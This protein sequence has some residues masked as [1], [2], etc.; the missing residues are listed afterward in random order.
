MQEDS[1]KEVGKKS[2]WVF[3]Y[4]L[5]TK[6]TKKQTL[7]SRKEMGKCLS[8]INQFVVLL[9]WGR[10]GCG[11]RSQEYF[12]ET[13]FCRKWRMKKC[14]LSLKLEFQGTE[15]WVWA[16]YSEK[17][18]GNLNLIY[19]FYHAQDLD[20]V[21]G[22]TPLGV[23]ENDLETELHKASSGILNIPNWHTVAV[24]SLGRIQLER[25]KDK[26]VRIEHWEYASV[27]SV[28]KHLVFS[29]MSLNTY[30]RQ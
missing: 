21:W 23:G 16:G 12:C 17:V 27:S 20:R 13:L 24:K 6:K 14:Y 8:S 5:K 1:S 28:F 18:I 29:S 26:V 4:L 25:W 15:R 22:S 7:D 11:T 10:V 19:T 2:S 9:L 30:C 3:L